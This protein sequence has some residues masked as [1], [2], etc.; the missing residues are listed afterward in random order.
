MSVCVAGYLYSTL[1]NLLF[2][3]Y[4]D[5]R[6]SKCVK[7]RQL[8]KRASK[9]KLQ[10]VFIIVNNLQQPSV[11]IS[12]LLFMLLP[13]SA[14]MALLMLTQVGSGFVEYKDFVTFVM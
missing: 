14:L 6:E 9:E 4:M 3:L 13:M 10:L 2:V 12:V 8:C 5:G 1:R 7:E 11:R